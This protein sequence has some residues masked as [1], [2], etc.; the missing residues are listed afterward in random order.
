VPVS[1]LVSVPKP[2]WQF[3][4]ALAKLRNATISFVMSVCL[5]GTARLPLDGFWWNLIFELFFR[6]PVVEK[7]KILFKSDKNNGYFTWRLSTFLTISRQILLRMENVLD[8]SCR[9]NWNTHFM[10]SSFFRK[11]H[12]LWNNVEKCGGHR[13]GPQMTSQ[14]GAYALHAGLARL[15]APMRIHTPT[16]QGTRTH[17]RKQTNK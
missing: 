13:G 11:S 7:I 14:Y 4:G 8:K 12:R 5:H 1:S 10:F 2:L 17:A 3:L 15:H 9:G 6:K 16:R